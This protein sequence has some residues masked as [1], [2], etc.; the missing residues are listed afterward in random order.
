[1][2]TFL[3]LISII[4]NCIQF[5][6]YRDKCCKLKKTEEKFKMPHEAG[7]PL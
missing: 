7:K 6:T 3:L 2:I 5:A 1:M 4:L